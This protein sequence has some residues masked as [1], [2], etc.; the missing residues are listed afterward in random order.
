MVNSNFH[1]AK[2]G[3]KRAAEVSG[4]SKTEEE[5]NSLASHVFAIGEAERGVLDFRAPDFDVQT[6]DAR[7]LAEKL[8]AL[9]D[10]VEGVRVELDTLNAMLG[11]FTDALIDTGQAA[12]LVRH[13]ETLKY[14]AQIWGGSPLGRYL[15]EC[16]SDVA[17]VV[18]AA[19]RAAS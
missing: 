2:E 16:M 14:N 8:K 18:S 15:R 1:A 19:E 13:A 3:I 12:F 4:L 17:I 11:E 7:T 10:M 6:E 5:V 9:R